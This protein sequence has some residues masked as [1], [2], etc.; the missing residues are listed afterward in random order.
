MIDMAVRGLFGPVID[1][2]QFGGRENDRENDRENGRENLHQIRNLILVIVTLIGAVTF[3]AGMNPPGGLW[4]DTQEGEDGHVAGCAIFA[5]RKQAA[6]Y[7]FLFFN[8]LAFL[9]STFI[10]LA[11]TQGF[12]FRFEIRLAI[13][14]IIVTYACAVAAITPPESANLAYCLLVALLPIVVSALIRRRRDERA[15]RDNNRQ[16]GVDIL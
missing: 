3:Q 2:I 9:I 6:Y 12:P 15:K 16:R 10:I 11:F 7:V 1:D 5:H 13:V 4:Q 14:S 8:T